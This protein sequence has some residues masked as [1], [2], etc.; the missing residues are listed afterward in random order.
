MTKLGQEGQL[1][2]GASVGYV[3]KGHFLG[4]TEQKSRSLA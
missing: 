1:R 2:T 4:D 3:T